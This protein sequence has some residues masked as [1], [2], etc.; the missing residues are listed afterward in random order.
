MKKQAARGF[1]DDVAASGQQESGF[2]EGREVFEFAVSVLVIGVSRAVRNANRQ[3]SDH[4]RDQIQRRVRRFRKDA[5]RTGGNSHHGLE[6]RDPK[7]YQDRVLRHRTLLEAHLSGREVARECFGHRSSDAGRRD[8][9]LEN[10]AG[11][12]LAN[13]ARFN[14]RC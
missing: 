4:R 6:Q 8:F 13:H 3:Q 14:G 7:G 5:Q 9:R 10:K 2:H 12:G 11:R 1:V